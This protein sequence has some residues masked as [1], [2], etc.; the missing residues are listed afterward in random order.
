[1]DT[2]GVGAA[3]SHCSTITGSL[4]HS[5]NQARAKRRLVEARRAA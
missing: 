3:A 5:H 1:M 2:A 4:Q